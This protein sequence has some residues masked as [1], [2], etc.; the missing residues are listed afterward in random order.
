MRIN[1]SQIISIRLKALMVIEGLSLLACEN[2]DDP[3]Y[4]FAHVAIG[5]CN[6][7]HGD[8]REELNRTWR[9]LIEKGII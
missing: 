1:M 5:D 6:N 8:W 2:K 7:P 9:E 4:R 3:I